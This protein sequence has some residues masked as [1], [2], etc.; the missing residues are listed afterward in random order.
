LRQHTPLSFQQLSWPQASDLTAQGL[1]LYRSCAQLFLEELL[2]FHDGRACLRSMITQLPEHWNWQTAFLQGFR[3]HFDQLLAVEKWWGVSYVD[4]T[5][6]YKIEA[7]SA[8]DARKKLQDSLDVPVNV[9]FGADQMPAEAKIT[10]QEVIRQWPTP[11]AIEALQRALVGLK[12]LAP[13]TAPELRPLVE[14]YGKT[15][16]DYLSVVEKAKLDRQLGKHTSSLLSG[17][18][19]EAIKQ[20]DALD[21]QREAIWT[22]SAPA[23][24]PQLSAAGEVETKSGPGR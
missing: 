18:K 1:P 13:R 15:L 17:A 5:R 4:F 22:N 7:W 14:L 11:D 21:R 3:S 10:L 20:L 2:R 19:A 24:L 16:L 9:H 23:H 12:F 6:G 8:A